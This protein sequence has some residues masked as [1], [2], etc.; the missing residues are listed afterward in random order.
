[1]KRYNDLLNR[2]NDS[3]NR[4]REYGYASAS[5]RVRVRGGG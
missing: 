2:Y 1:M 5:T 4:V 3:A